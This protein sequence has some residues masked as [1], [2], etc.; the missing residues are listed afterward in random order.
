MPEH[1]FHVERLT[2]VTIPQYAPDV[3]KE[4]ATEAWVL[5]DTVHTDSSIWRVFDEW[6]ALVPE[7]QKQGGQYRVIEMSTYASGI[8]QISCH[9]VKPSWSVESHWEPKP[10]EDMGEADV[11]QVA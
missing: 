6:F 2:S 10:E 5:L 4:Y 7:D 11:T 9:T 3:M 8:G 1:I